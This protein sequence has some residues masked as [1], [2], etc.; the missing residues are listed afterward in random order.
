LKEIIIFLQYHKSSSCSFISEFPQSAYAIH[1]FGR[2][3]PQNPEKKLFKNFDFQMV[4]SFITSKN[5]LFYNEIQ[6]LML[7]NNVC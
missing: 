6:Q 1:Q 7:V 2:H 3:E 5:Y 4:E